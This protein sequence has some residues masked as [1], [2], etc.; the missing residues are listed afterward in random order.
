M[1][2][3]SSTIYAQNPLQPYLQMGIERLLDFALQ[4]YC[5]NAYLGRCRSIASESEFTL[6]PSVER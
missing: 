5:R 3:L 4:V 1:L 2:F 6:V